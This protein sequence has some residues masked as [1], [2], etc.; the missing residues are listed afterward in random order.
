MHRIRMAAMAAA[1]TLAAVAA[2]SVPAVSAGEPAPGSRVGVRV[3]TVTVDDYAPAFSLTGSVMARAT[4]AL[5]FRVGGRVIERRADVGDRVRK[6]E[7]LARLD[8]SQQRADVDNGEATV[9]A[10]EAAL[11][12][13]EAAF[14]RQRT[15][16]DKGFTTQ[17]DFDTA[18]KSVRTAE[19]QLDGARTMLDLARTKLGYADL[20]ADADGVVISRTIDVGEVAPAAGTIYTVA[21]D[22]PRDAVFDIYE[23]AFLTDVAASTI[24]VSLVSDPTVTA[25]GHLREIS[26][27]V[28]S[29]TGTVRVKVDI[30]T[31]PSDMALGAVVAGTIQ[32]VP[33]KA[34]T[35]P[36][37]ALASDDGRPAVWIVAE[38]GE[39]VA[40][41]DIDV[42][43]Y[44]SDRIIVRDGLKAGER[45]VVAGGKFLGRG[46]KIRIEGGNPS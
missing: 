22:G 38:D 24:V 16:L 29:I 41:R 10:A 37:S 18:Q 4:S 36:S 7:V 6:G 1:L 43:A 20:V 14:D 40:L 3:V 35:L 2:F 44:E 25:A 5:S 23:Q 33:C 17:S 13:A 15:L 28:N 12:Q 11:R 46:M 19:S 30:G 32:A 45:V 42:A 8:A 21:V 39:S 9:A 34:V 26:P 31:P 27:T